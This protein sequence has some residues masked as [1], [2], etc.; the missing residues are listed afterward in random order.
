MIAGNGEE[1][2]PERLEKARS[3]L[4]LVPLRAVR[5]VAAG[6]DQV[7]ADALHQLR[8]AELDLGVVAGPE[9][10]VG[11]VENAGGHDRGRL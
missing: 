2:R 5:Q 8:Q 3:R 4:V 1:G 6:D 11:D 10:K 9:M 7:G